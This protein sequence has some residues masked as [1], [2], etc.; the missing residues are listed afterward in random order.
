MKAFWRLA[1][2]AALAAGAATAAQAAGAP[3]TLVIREGL[4]AEQLAGDGKVCLK[5]AKAAER[6]RPIAPL[7]TTGG[8]AARMAGA[9]AAGAMKGWSDIKRFEIA[10]DAC[11][12][13]LGYRQVELTPEQRQE[14]KQLKTSAERLGYIV[15]FSRRAIAAGK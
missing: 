8:T 14:Y 2:F 5:E 1:A 6:G 7:P 13:R 10:H 12:D 15:E 9:A 3:K 4:T 11:L